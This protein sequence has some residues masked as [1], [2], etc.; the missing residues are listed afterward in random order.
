MF[1]IVGTRTNCK[2]IPGIASTNK[3]ERKI[4]NVKLL[5]VNP[6]IMAVA[7]VRTIRPIISAIDSVRY[8]LILHFLNLSYNRP[9]I[10]P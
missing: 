6:K 5:P 2:I 3:A 8:V 9:Q 1:M 10:I 4:E 7:H